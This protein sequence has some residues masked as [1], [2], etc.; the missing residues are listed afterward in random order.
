MK[1][2]DSSLFIL[3][4]KNYLLFTLTLLLT[5]VGIYWLWNTQIERIFIPADWDGLLADDRLRKGDY[6][7]LNSYISDSES[8]FSVLDDS[9]NVL[10]R[11]DN[12]FNVQ[13]TMEELSLVREY[14]SETY[15]ETASHLDDNGRTRYIVIKHT[16][17]LDG[18]YQKIESMVLDENYHVLSGGLGDGRTGY[19]KEEYD[20]LT[21]ASPAYTDLSYYKF[22][23]VNGYERTILM[24]SAYMDEK[25]YY[26]LFHASWRIWLLF[27]PL[28]VIA[29]GYFI[30]RIN[31]T[32]RRPLDRLHEAVTAQSEGRSVRIGNYGGTREIQQISESFDLLTTRLEESENERRALDQGRQK[33]IADISHDLKTPVTVIAGY[34]N[35]LYDEKVPPGEVKRYLNAIHN[36][37]EALTE[38]INAFH[39]YSKVEHPE[40]SLYLD[41]TDICEFLREYL[42]G[43]YDEI[44]LA[45]FTL[46]VSIPERPVFCKLDD[47]QFR[48]VLDNLLSNSIRYNMLGTILF[49]DLVSDST[50]AVIFAADNGSGIPRERIKTIFDPF[51]VGNDARNCGGSGLGLAITKRIVELHGG[52]ITLTA[53]PSRGRNAEFIIKIPLDIEK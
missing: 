20:I 53:S 1:S 2:K 49:F 52:T 40:L 35:A 10:F 36:R 31:R 44:H 16:M 29:T 32:I 18:A 48:R 19:T 43:K 9:G 14:Y 4:T 38:L 25:S 15:F 5:A 47:V 24:K 50:T 3:L 37:T 27:L 41:R 17:G 51:V 28:Y 6:D 11:S 23:D 30:W 46:E 34:V 7:R 42:A 13:L 21:E 12:R 39:E 26:S 45:G 33:L 8:A 22:I